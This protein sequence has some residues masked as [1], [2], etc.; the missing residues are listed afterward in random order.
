MFS[1]VNMESLFF[2]FC[3]GDE[4]QDSPHARQV[5]YHRAPFLA[6]DIFNQHKKEWYFQESSTD[7]EFRGSFWQEA[8]CVD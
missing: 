3:A 2:F 1:L 4:I 5:L 7:A 8:V 6:L